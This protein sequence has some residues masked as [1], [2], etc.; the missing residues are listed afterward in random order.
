MTATVAVV[1]IVTMLTIGSM[2]GNEDE[3]TQICMGFCLFDS[4]TDV[5]NELDESPGKDD[6]A[7]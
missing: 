1:F 2:K 7:G 5:S 4:R 3:E 6:S